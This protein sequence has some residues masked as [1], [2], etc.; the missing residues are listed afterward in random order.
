L[1]CNSTIALLALF[2]QGKRSGLSRRREERKKQIPGGNDS[3]KG[4]SK[5]NG[6]SKGKGKANSNGN[7]QY[8]GLSTAVE[9]TGV[10]VG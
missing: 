3:K 6:N 8:R 2:R 10:V 4:N 5:G 1:G 7:S 9:R